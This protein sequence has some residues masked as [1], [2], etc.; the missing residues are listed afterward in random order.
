MLQNV[1]FFFHN[2]QYLNKLNCLRFF[3]SL[4]SNYSS[5]DNPKSLSFTL[6]LSL[7]SSPLIFHRSRSIMTTASPNSTPKPKVLR[8]GKIRF[9]QEKW[10]EVSKYAEVVDCDSANREQ[11][12]KDLQGKYSDVTNISRT[13]ESVAQTGRF[14]EEVAAHVP[15]TLVSVSHTGAGYDQVDVEPFTKRGIQ[16]SNI[17]V[18]VEAPTA[19]TAVWLA[20]T[21]LRNYKVASD[22][23]KQGKWPGQA[24]AGAKLGHSPEGKVVGIM[25]MGGIGRAIRDRLK[26]FGFEKIIYYNRS[27]L[28]PKLEAGAEYV[29]KEELFKQSDIIMISIPLNAHTRH[30]IDKSAIEQM[31]D[32]VILVNTARGAVIKESELPELIKSGKIGALGAD[33]F[34]NEPEIPKELLELPQVVALP[35]VGTYTS[36]AIK[37][38]EDWVADN[39]LSAIKTGKVK[40]IVP[41]QKDTKFD[42]KPLV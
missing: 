34:E 1:F 29:S 26:P 28:D 5:L 7:L 19:D 21:C 2:K 22:L 10:D 41:E 13:F 32:G 40:S 25:G 33:V 20:I 12:L 27:R 14:D 42:V 18:P 37:N 8:L 15:K 11:F 23:V 9:G 39:V 17:T 6:R 4:S 36:E 38:M 35:H 30:S 16:V 31:K 24:A 3:Q